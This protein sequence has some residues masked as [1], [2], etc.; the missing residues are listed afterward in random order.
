MVLAQQPPCHWIASAHGRLLHVSASGAA[1]C[2]SPP[3][4][5]PIHARVHLLVTRHALLLVGHPIRELLA[6]KAPPPWSHPPCIPHAHGLAHLW[7]I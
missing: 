5:P 3:L 7:Q 1:V 2:D 6:P 4:I